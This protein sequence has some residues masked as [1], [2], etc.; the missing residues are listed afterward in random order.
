MELIEDKKIS[1]LFKVI[2]VLLVIFIIVPLAL[3][4]INFWGTSLSENSTSWGDFGSYFGGIIGTIFNAFAVTIALISIYISLRITT[5]IQEAEN[6]YKEETIKRETERFQKEIELTHKQNKPFPY[7]DLSRLKNLTK[8]TLSNYGTGPMVVKEII[9]LYDNNEAYS[10]IVQLVKNKMQAKMKDTII[11]YNSG[12][13]HIIPAGGSKNLAEILPINEP[14]EYFE[15][16]QTEIRDLLNKCKII[17]T[18][19][20][21]FE[22]EDKIQFSLEFIHN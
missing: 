17:V 15:I 8:I 14:T 18:Y 11:N 22:K 19:E 4:I 2:I 1:K 9:I 6:K 5:K 16:V 3:Y 13:S 12:P 7:L 10:H 21:L 20:D